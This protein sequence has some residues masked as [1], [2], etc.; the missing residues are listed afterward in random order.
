MMI[1]LP[2]N[3]PLFKGMLVYHPKTFNVSNISSIKESGTVTLG[4]GTLEYGRSLIYP[5]A[6][7]QVKLGFFG[8]GSFKNDDK[9]F[10]HEPV[11]DNTEH[12]FYGEYDIKEHWLY[13]EGNGNRIEMNDVKFLHQIQMGLINIGCIN[14]AINTVVLNTGKV[15]TIE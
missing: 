8:F 13:L 12:N 2:N 4:S 3:F 7:T 15:K 9:S 6:I 1:G 11:K 10:Y 14:L 5:V